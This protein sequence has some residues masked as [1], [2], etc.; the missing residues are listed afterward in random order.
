M[1]SISLREYALLLRRT[2]AA[3]P[4]LRER[5]VTAELSDVTVR[6]GHCYMELVEKT[7]TGQIA[8]KMRATIWQSVYHRLRMKFIQAAGRE[9]SSGI[10]LMVR[11]SANIHEVFGLS[12]NVSDIDPSYT[13]GDMERVRREILAALKREGL[14]D[15]NLSLPMPDAP[16]RIAVISAAGAAGYGDFMNQLEGNPFG[17]VFYTKLFQAVMQGE[18]T[19]ESVRNALDIIEM[20]VDFWDCVVIIRGGGATTDL[21]GFDEL[22]LARRVASYP[23]PIIVGIGHERDRTVLDEIANVRVKTPTAAAEWLVNSATGVLARIS[24][25]CR[26]IATETSERLRGAQRQLSWLQTQIHTGASTRLSA[27]S[28]RLTALESLIPSL[29]RRQMDIARQRVA[30]AGT[31]VS[32]AGISR[33]AQMRDRLGYLSS[34]LLQSA[35]LPL[36]RQQRRLENLRGLVD[37]LSPENTLRRGYSLTI[38]DSRIVKNPSGLRE[39]ETITTL[40]AG[41]KAESVISKIE[42]NGK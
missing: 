38:R 41:G 6:G 17:I 4:E 39:G 31:L 2:V 32:G 24:D 19:S 34:M 18:R 10:K 30:S 40:F 28:G 3:C 1:E 15:Y 21:T 29:A 36:E 14:A 35:Y 22:E 23:I 5:W 13:L 33:V 42:T 27:A 37:V 26:L 12:F 7:P 11:G 20:S 16:Q 25:L 8:A 9:I